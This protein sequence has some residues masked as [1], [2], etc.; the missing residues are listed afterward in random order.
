MAD[1]LWDIATS[2]PAI[3]L[4]AIAVAGLFIVGHLPMNSPYAAPAKLLT[5]VAVALLFFL[6]GFHVADQ[7]AEAAQLSAQLRAKQLDLD[8]SELAR[9]RAEAAEKEIKARAAA[10]EKRIADYEVELQNRPN[11]A[12]L[13]TDADIRWMRNNKANRR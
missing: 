9:G 12:C 8:A 6:V 2:W 1:I 5:P 11:A 13:L 4:V 7:R 3:G 10:D